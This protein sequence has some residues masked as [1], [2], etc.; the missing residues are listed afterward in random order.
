VLTLEVFRR[1]EGQ[2]EQ[3]IPELSECVSRLTLDKGLFKVEIETYKKSFE[4]TQAAHAG[5]NKFARKLKLELATSLDARKRSLDAYEELQRSRVE[6]QK[7]L[8]T[9]NSELMHRPATTSQ[10]S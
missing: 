3:Q 2:T 9:R 4:E 8:E 7:N 1:D 5:C 10:L 6:L